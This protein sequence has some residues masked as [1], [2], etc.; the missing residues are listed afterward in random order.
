MENKITCVFSCNPTSAAFFNGLPSDLR[1]TLLRRLEFIAGTVEKVAPNAVL[2]SAFR[3]PRYSVSIG[4][5][6]NSWHGFGCALDYRL[7][8][9]SAESIEKLRKV[10]FFVLVETNCIHVQFTGDL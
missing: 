10:G 2:T 6:P 1:K 7:N 9:I 8:T 4:S 5:H 3:S